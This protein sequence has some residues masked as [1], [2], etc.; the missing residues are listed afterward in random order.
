MQEINVCQYPLCFLCHFLQ[1]S[2]T[3]NTVKKMLEDL[4]V[5]TLKEREGCHAQQTKFRD[6]GGSK[7]KTTI[8]LSDLPNFNFDFN[9]RN[10]SEEELSFLIEFVAS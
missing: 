10:L 3:G 4:A 2:R 5:R 1:T 7:L 6:C 8:N 9:L